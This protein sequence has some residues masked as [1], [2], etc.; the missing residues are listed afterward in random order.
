VCAPPTT[1]HPP[2]T[3]LSAP[4][5]LPARLRKRVISSIC[6]VSKA[7]PSGRSF[8]ALREAVEAAAP[9]A[10]AAA[11][12]VCVCVCVCMGVREFFLLVASGYLV[13]G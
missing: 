2:H 10:A 4:A 8:F 12:C 11:V 1:P 6:N 13:L 7:K 3:H 5:G 9:A